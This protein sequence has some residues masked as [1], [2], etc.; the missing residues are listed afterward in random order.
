[1]SSKHSLYEYHVDYIIK[2]DFDNDKL[3]KITFL[4]YSVFYEILSRNN[5]PS[6]IEFNEFGAIT[7]KVFYENDVLKR[8]E[9]YSR[10]A[11]F[12]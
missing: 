5:E 10:T 4:K 7:K 8:V 9:D 1:M 12:K 6:I 11:Y 3:E 2:K